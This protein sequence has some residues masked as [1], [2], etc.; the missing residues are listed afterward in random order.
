MTCT[1]GKSDS[2]DVTYCACV[3]EAGASIRGCTVIE[4]ENDLT[5]W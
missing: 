5:I 4:S 2:E 3:S 1:D